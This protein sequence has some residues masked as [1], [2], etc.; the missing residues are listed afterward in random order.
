MPDFKLSWNISCPAIAKKG[1]SDVCKEAL[2]H[3]MQEQSCHWTDKIRALCQQADSGYLFVW[4]PWD[5]QHP[6]SCL[7][8]AQAV[9][10]TQSRVQ[11]QPEGGTSGEL[12]DMALKTCWDHKPNLRAGEC[13]KG[14]TLWLCAQSAQ[15]PAAKN[16]FVCHS[17]K[18][19]VPRLDIVTD[20]NHWGIVLL[21]I[22]KRA[23]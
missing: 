20:G 19:E 6:Q 13:F 15:N 23:G 1:K 11:P 12:L 3:D 17:K 14:L 22:G 4:D 9:S 8:F 2:E 10:V 5:V 7:A 21:R 18:P 16:A